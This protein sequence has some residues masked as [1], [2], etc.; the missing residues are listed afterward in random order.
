MNSVITI[1]GVA[2][3]L[4]AFVCIYN[5]VN[6][7]RFY[8]QFKTWNENVKN[9]SREIDSSMRDALAQNTIMVLEKLEEKDKLSVDEFNEIINNNDNNLDENEEC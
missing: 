1:F 3:C 4:I 5:L 9:W 7:L 6:Y 2:I 8:G